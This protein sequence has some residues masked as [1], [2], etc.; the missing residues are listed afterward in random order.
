MAGLHLD[1]NLDLYLLLLLPTLLWD[2]LLLKSGL[3]NTTY[4]LSCFPA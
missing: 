2:E 1:Q 3:T 4:M